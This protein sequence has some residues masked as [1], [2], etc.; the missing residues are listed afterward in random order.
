MMQERLSK[1]TDVHKIIAK[2]LK[3][4]REFQ[5]MSQQEFGEKIGTSGQN[6]YRYE[7]GVV[8]VPVNVLLDIMHAFN[9]SLEYFVDE[10]STP[11][12]VKEIIRTEYSKPVIVTDE[13]EV[14]F[15]GKRKFYAIPILES[16]EVIGK[17]NN[18]GTVIKSAVKDYVF[19]PELPL[20]EGEDL[21]GFEVQD[22]SSY[23]DAMVG[24]YVIIKQFKEDPI[25]KLSP[26]YFL[27]PSDY[28]GLYAVRIV[29]GTELAITIRRVIKREKELICL[30]NNN[31]FDPIILRKTSSIEQ[32]I[33]NVIGIYRIRDIDKLEDQIVHINPKFR[34][35]L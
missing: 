15:V 5:K 3:D 31:F 12:D 21:Y 29:V 10:N 25:K 4:L 18:V 16:S 2:K 24:D 33:G 8:N 14:D 6:I 1:K 11:L 7:N 34:N 35:I 9:L 13:D 23:P 32:P 28:Q 19:I 30:A 20:E 26:K 27:Q 17:N 22:G